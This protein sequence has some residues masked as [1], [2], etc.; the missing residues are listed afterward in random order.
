MS[1]FRVFPAVLSSLLVAADDA[2]YSLVGCG[3]RAGQIRVTANPDGVEAQLVN[4]I[5]GGGVH[6]RFRIV[7]HTLVFTA[8]E[9]A[10]HEVASVFHCPVA[11]AG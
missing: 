3:G 10:C 11:R 4:L 2:G 5:V 9:F 8:E 1:K 7:V 6:S